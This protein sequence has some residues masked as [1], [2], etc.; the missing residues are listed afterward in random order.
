MPI[1]AAFFAWGSVVTVFGVE[2]SITQQR[3]FAPGQDHR[4]YILLHG[5]L[6]NYCMVSKNINILEK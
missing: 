5:I 3:W 4:R 6:S 1:S 2:V